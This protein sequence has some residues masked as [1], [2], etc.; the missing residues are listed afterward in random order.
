MQS[1][2][3][4]CWI[5]S[6]RWQRHGR[7]SSFCKRCDL[8]TILTEENTHKG[9]NQ[10][11]CTSQHL[12]PGPEETVAYP[13][14]L[15]ML[16]FCFWSVYK[17][18][19]VKLLEFCLEFSPY[20]KERHQLMFSLAVVKPVMLY[21]SPMW[22]FC[23]NELLERILALQNR[24]AKKIAGGKFSSAEARALLKWFPLHGRHFGHQSLT[25]HSPV[26]RNLQFR[27]KCLLLA[28]LSNVHAV[29]WV[30]H[31]SGL[32]KGDC[33]KVKQSKLEKNYWAKCSV[34]SLPFSVIKGELYYYGSMLCL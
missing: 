33:W 18:T 1:R 11:Q 7:D 17:A 15:S 27:I 8:T 22:S 10:Q 21:L 23:S 3:K 6:K 12:Q 30:W 28:S 34:L 5:C 16:E 19:G 9:L 20:L 2:Q 32:V 25:F 24:F 14:T 26:Y 13:Q 31:H 4:Y 29:W